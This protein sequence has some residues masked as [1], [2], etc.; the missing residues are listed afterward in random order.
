MNADEF[1]VEVDQKA[2]AAL[3]MLPV[4][5]ALAKLGITEVY[6]YSLPMRM[7]FRG[8]MQRQGVLLQGPTGWGEFSP[9]TE[10]EVPEAS[11]WLL[12]AIEAAT[13]TE[14]PRLP[15]HLNIGINL[16]V[17]VVSADRAQELAAASGATTAKIKVADP[18]STLAEDCAR[19]EAVAATLGPQAKIR[20]DANTAWDV[21]TAVHAIKELD[22]AAQLGAG[23]GVLSPP[24][25][26]GLDYVE[27]PCATL[28]ELAA[29]RNQVPV[30]IAADE[31]IRRASDPAEAIRLR[32]ADVM[33]V[34]VQPLG[35]TQRCLDLLAGEDVQVVVSSALESSIGIA[36]G[37]R[38]A[39]MLPN[40]AGDCG[41]GTVRLFTAEVSRSVLLPH[42][43]QIALAD[44]LT[45]ATQ[46]VQP[47]HGSIPATQRAW[48]LK[49][50]EE[51]LTY[52]GF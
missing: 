20:V 36:H 31:S 5:S 45:T 41:L 37:V 42:G 19:V 32:A 7:R 17:P 8:I 51:C 28:P 29:V 26:T 23:G 33:V 47:V 6:L 22:R 3:A 11:N 9:F 12:S 40:L 2:E 38:L 16:T 4:P 21:E 48:W 43:N 52:L 39:S 15:L 18:N 30:R 14:L 35:G 10:Y 44:A 50:I 46:G 34:K 24:G 25:V 27:Q 1:P 49:R 13:L